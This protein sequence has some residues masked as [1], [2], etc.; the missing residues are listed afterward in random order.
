[1]LAAKH[2]AEH[3]VPKEELE[4]I[5]E[6]RWVCSNSVVGG[7]NSVNRAESLELAGT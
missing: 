6:L 7:H 1:M 2:W 5:K 4:K 3:M